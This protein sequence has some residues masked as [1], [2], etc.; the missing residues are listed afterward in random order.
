MLGRLYLTF[1]RHLLPRIGQAIAPNADNAYDYLPRSVL[2]FPDGQ[3]ML[4]LLARAR[5]DRAEQYP[6]TRGIATLYVGTKPA[7]PAAPAIQGDHSMNR[8][9]PPRSPGPGRRHDR[10]QRCSLCRA[11]ASGPQPIRTH[12]SSHGQLERRS[13][14]SRGAGAGGFARL[15]Q[16]RRSAGIAP[17]RLVY[18]HY[19]DFNAPIASGSFP[20]GGMVI[21][22]CSMSTLGSIAAG[23]TSNLITRAADVHLKERRKLILVPRETPLEPDPSREH[24]EGDPRR[25]DRPAGD[26]RLV[27][28]AP[29]DSRP[30][31]FRRRAH[32]R[33]AWNPECPGAALGHRTRLAIRSRRPI[34]TR[35]STSRMPLDLEETERDPLARRLSQ[36]RSTPARGGARAAP[37]GLDHRCFGRPWYGAGAR[38][39]AAEKGRCSRADGPP[40]RSAGG[41]GAASSRQADPGCRDLDGRGRPRRSRDARTSGRGDDAADSGGST[42]SINNAGLGLPTLFEDAEPEQLDRQLAVNLTAP[43]LLTRLCLPSLVERKGMIINIGS[44]ITCVA[45]SALGAYGATKAGLA[46][47]NDALRREL[48]SRGVNVCLVEPGPIK[49]EFM[50]ALS[51]SWCRRAGAR[52]R[53]STTRRR[54]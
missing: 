48:A 45:N 4:D 25:C 6:L 10:R 24:G 13:G 29:A 21:V 41:A 40:R 44:A 31:R 53:F 19:Q 16:S 42:C 20:T 2:A 49:T 12:D 39:G 51:S 5:I 23:A 17:D 32:L 26:A 1:F 14:A 34:A 35:R 36:W 47:W 7:V 11:A 3:A 50:D 38:A 46:Y 33:S 28:P 22:P 52:T 15:V 8:A 43:L 37:G 54:G 30:D 9:G 27:S 18:H